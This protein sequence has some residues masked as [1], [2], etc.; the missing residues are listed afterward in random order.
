MTRF[1]AHAN[2]DFIGL[3]HYA[4]G[5]TAAIIVPGLIWILFGGLNYS[6]EFTGGTLVQVHTRAARRRRARSARRW[7]GPGCTTPRSSSSARRRTT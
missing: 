1:F 7:T 5:L 3:R 4:Y 6:I 2:Y